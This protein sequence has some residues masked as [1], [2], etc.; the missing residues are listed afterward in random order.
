MN[1]L[2]L[3]YI[4]L[5]IKFNIFFMIII[6]NFYYLLMIQKLPHHQQITS[7]CFTVNWSL[8]ESVRA[9]QKQKI[10]ESLTVKHVFIDLWLELGG[11]SYP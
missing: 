4:W 1:S 5:L 9:V 11:Y 6:N 3:A 2:F 10:N 7:Y 8:T